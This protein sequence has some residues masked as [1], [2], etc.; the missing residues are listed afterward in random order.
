MTASRDKV[1]KKEATFTLEQWKNS[2]IEVFSVA[3]E[4]EARKLA[5]DYRKRPDCLRVRWQTRFGEF[6]V[7]VWMLGE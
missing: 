6:A 1:S 5:A 3:T 7:T 2:R 4:A